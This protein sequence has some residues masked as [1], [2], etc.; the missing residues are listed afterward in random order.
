M[1]PLQLPF[2]PLQFQK[3][4][5]FAIAILSV[6]ISKTMSVEIP[7]TMRP[8]QLPFYPSQFQTQCAFATAILTE[9]NI[10][11]AGFLLF[12]T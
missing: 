11:E 6:A 3:Q 4:C 1:R 10:L 8:S 2:Y 7:N 12:S 5:A 9:M